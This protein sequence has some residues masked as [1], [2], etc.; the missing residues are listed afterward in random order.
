MRVFGLPGVLYHIGRHP[1]VDLSPEGQERLRYLSCFKA[2]RERG[3]SAQ[4]VAGVLGLPCSTLYRWLKHLKEQGAKGLDERSRKPHRLRQ[5][6]WSTDLILAV[7]RWR[8]AYPAWGKG[9]LTPLLQQ[10]GWLVSE[11]TVGRVLA[12]LRR[13]GQI[14]PAPVRSRSR[15]RRRQQRRPWAQR[16]PKG[17]PV[18]RPGDL[19]QVD[20]LD[21]RPLPGV[22]LKQLTA[23]DVV[24]RWDVLEVFSRATAHAARSFLDSLKERCPFPV[25]ALQVDG[26]SEFMAEFEE[27]CSQRGILLF[28][29]P[30]RSPKL[31]GY[32]ERA[33]GTHR[34]EFYEAYDLPWTVSE[35]RPHLRRWEWTYNFLRP[36]QAL[37]NCTPA[38]YLKECYPE[39]APRINCLTCIEL[40]HSIESPLS[41]CYNRLEV[42]LWTCSAD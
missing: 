23:R 42:A 29:L 37:D 36:H 8:Q 4:E 3:L 34:Y 2:L 41:R 18:Q 12:Y 7:L 38:Q 14:E 5:P 11:S 30:P 9:K 22:T 31:N 39:V 10:E 26:G 17:Y 19:V 25:R 35:L 33:Q 13:R 32:V 40:G 21:M 28:V 1:P 16:L 6:T 24:S 27:E 15:R 20:T